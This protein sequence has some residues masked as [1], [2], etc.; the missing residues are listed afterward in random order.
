MAERAQHVAEFQQKGLSLLAL[1]KRG[2]PLFDTRDQVALGN[3]RSFER[4]H[5]LTCGRGE[6]RETSDEA[7]I[8]SFEARTGGVLDDP[9]GPDRLAADS[10]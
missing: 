10:K 1:A 2:G 7:G 9:Y 3:L 5:Y 4:L 8:F 6:T